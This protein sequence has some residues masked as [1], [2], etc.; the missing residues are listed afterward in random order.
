MTGLFN[1][2]PKH[3]PL[4]KKQAD[5]LLQDF[6]AMPDLAPIVKKH[7]AFFGWLVEASPFLSR[8]IKRYPETLSALIGETPDAYLDNLLDTLS[9]DVEAAKNRDAVMA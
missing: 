3:K 6:L 2:L 7:A 1:T 8:L 5:L 4:D 9:Q